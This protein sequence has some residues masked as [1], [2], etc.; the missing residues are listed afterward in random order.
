MSTK[1]KGGVM[2]FVLGLIAALIFG[3]WIFP[4]IIFSHQEQPF[5]YSHEA[6]MK[7]VG[8]CSYCHYFR[9]DGSFSGIPSLDSCA[10]C[11]YEVLTGT[12]DEKIFVNEYVKKDKKVP[13][14]V[15]QSQPDNVYFS[16]MAHKEYECT[17]CHP[18]VGHSKTLPPY[19]R[20]KLTGYSKQ[21]MTMDA[22]ERCHAEN[23]ASN[24]CYVCHK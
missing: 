2:P 18:D 3:W 19:Y 16:H 1:N 17:E 5:N 14:K 22:C 11:H 12:P 8:E 6:H 21:T 23:D 24:A 10:M 7:E 9:E 13:W 15:Y 4:Q 20:N